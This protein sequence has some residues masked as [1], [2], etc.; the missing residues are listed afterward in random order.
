MTH[1][2]YILSTYG[3]PVWLQTI[4]ISNTVGQIISTQS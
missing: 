3:N 1:D 4:Q 2:S